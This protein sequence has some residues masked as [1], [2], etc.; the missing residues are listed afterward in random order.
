MK[1]LVTGSNG[2]LGRE[3]TELLKRGAAG[4]FTVPK[5]Y[6]DAEVSSVDIDVLDI[7]DPIATRRYFEALRPD[8]VINCAA[9]TNVDGC[10]THQD[11]AFRANALGAR[12]AAEAAAAIDAGFVHI[13]T[14]YVFPGD[15][16]TPYAE[17]DAPA[18]LSAYG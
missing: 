13:S 5:A 6:M 2:Q 7:A 12:S 17:W 14:D 1:L 11:E 4:P 3:L 9:Y 10:E 18:P 15:G 8:I 16:N